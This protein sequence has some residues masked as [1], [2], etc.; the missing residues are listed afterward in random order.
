MNLPWNQER[1]TVLSVATLEIFASKTVALLTRTA[2]RDLYDIHNMIKYGL[3]DES[4]EDM[5]RKCAVFYSAIGAELPPEKFE[6][7]HITK[8]SSQQIKRDL[9]PVLRKGE[10]FDLEVVQKEVKDYLVSIMIP[11]EEE[12]NFWRA[13][14]EGEYYPKLVFGESQELQNIS[15]HPMALWKCRDKYVD[16]SAE[17]I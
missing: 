6:L 10:K 13:F 7:D 12:E 3:F 1:L 9:N 17:E 4:E 5:L 8:I 15:G 2:P 14:A 16:S 11:T